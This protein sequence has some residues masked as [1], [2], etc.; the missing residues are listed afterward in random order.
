MKTR[1]IV[2]S[3]GFVLFLLGSVVPAQ[4]IAS[5]ATYSKVVQSTAL[6]V[7]SDGSAE[8]SQMLSPQNSSSVTLPLLTTQIGNILARDQN[9]SAVSYQISGQNIT[10]STFGVKSVTLV[11]DT[12]ALTNK[13]GTTWDLNFN[14]PFN[15]TLTLPFQSTVLSVSRAPTTFSTVN[16]KPVLFLA[17][18]SWQINYGLPLS[19]P[20]TTSS[21][22][23]SSTNS[24]SV[25]QSQPPS[26]AQQQP[27]LLALGGVVVALIVA[28]AF[29]MGRS[30]LRIVNRALRYDDK[31]I[32]NFIREKGGKVSEAEIRERFSLP[33]TS[34]WRQAKRLEKLGYVR[35][36][37]TGSQNQVELL[38]SSSEQQK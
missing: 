36:T 2:Y 9:G 8:V 27:Q 5:V 23:S 16:G 37:K 24:G 28:V 13:Q 3:V 1:L 20:R 6:S 38:R 15:I 11:Y 17:P 18:G 19:V 21:T 22:S 4:S 30:K 7:F 31:E 29:V 32:L 25:V 26:I 35:I 34:A 12:N 14:S 33:R 10:L